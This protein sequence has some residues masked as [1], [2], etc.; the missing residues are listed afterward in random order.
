MSK[1]PLPLNPSPL[2]D[3]PPLPPS[4]PSKPSSPLDQP[5]VEPLIPVPWNI[6]RREYS[7]MEMYQEPPPVESLL[8]DPDSPIEDALPLE[9]ELFIPYE[10]DVPGGNMHA[11]SPEES[12]VIPWQEYLAPDSPVSCKRSLSPTSPSSASIHQHTSREGSYQSITPSASSPIAGT[13][14]QSQCHGQT[15]V[16]D[17][18]WGSRGS[19]IS[20]KIT[21]MGFGEGSFPEGKSVT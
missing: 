6:H 21:K 2:P 5:P 13:S 16:L 20:D 4:E 10:P 7:S 1:R 17:R 8:E 9:P 12:P 3:L 19:G 15:T 11:L 18:V 14:P